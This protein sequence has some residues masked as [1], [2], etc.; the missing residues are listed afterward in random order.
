MSQLNA[1]QRDG[2]GKVTISAEAG[3]AFV[4]GQRGA[5]LTA[6]DKGYDEARLV[7]NKCIDKRP[8][9]IARCTGV[10]DVI[11]AVRFAR[12][13][14]LMVAV[15]GGAHNVAG[16]AVCDGGL[17]IDLGPMNQVSVDVSARR[18]RAGGGATIGDVDHET[19]AFGLAVPLGVVSQTG[20]G[21][22]TLCGGHSWLNRKYGFACDNLVSIDMVTADGRYLTASEREN[23]DL[24]WAVRGGGGNFG[25]VTAFEYEAHPIGPEITFCATFYPMEAAVTVFR[26]WRDYVA[27]APDEFT[28]QVALWS[29]PPH[30]NFPA[31][32][33]G[34]PMVVA[35]GV[36]CG[37][38]E[39]GARY[40]QPLREL[41]TPL[42]DHSG[43]VPYKL[44]QQAFDPFFKTKGERFNYWKSL[45]LDALDD[46]A[47]DRIVARALDR[48]TSWTLI[49]VRL[50]GG[51]GGRVPA[52]ATALGGRDAAYMLS[53][54]TSW[55]EPDD[56][57]RA[58]AW[59]RA[60]WEEMRQ[61][62][63][64]S[65]YLNFVGDGDDTPAMLRASYGSDNYD[66]LVE[67]KTKYDPSN[68]F[69]LNQNIRPNTD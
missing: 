55:T 68:L 62:G 25:V 32:L 9:L 17:V 50:M 48:P 8:A 27:D 2:N 43:P 47:I 19:L 5:C 52:N 67:I 53:I 24:F 3:E 34:R 46:A 1:V 12:A 7:W 40:I 20:I 13:N 57:D 33:H 26:G 11:E 59:T 58:V 16:N 69:R 23:S 22:L 29:I 39:E 10:A 38:L 41:G 18:V 30:E 6:D 63:D 65:I 61:D 42:F 14:D 31:E 37:T 21:G 51:A 54:D 28:T 35:A 66:R 15:R 36:H 44:V 60:F 49:P 4:S 64:G 45:Y 56:G